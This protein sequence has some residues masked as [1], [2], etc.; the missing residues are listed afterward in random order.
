[1]VPCPN[2]LGGG[3]RPHRLGPLV[4]RHSPL[5][6]PRA[7]LVR[8][9]RVLWAPRCNHQSSL[10][11]RHSSCL[12]FIGLDL[13][14]VSSKSSSRSAPSSGLSSQPSSGLRPRRPGSLAFWHSPLCTLRASLVRAVRLH[15]NYRLGH[16]ASGPSTSPSGA[17]IVL[18]QASPSPS[19][20]PSLS[21]VP[22]LC[23]SS[24]GPATLPSWSPNL[25]AQSSSSV[26]FERAYF[27]ECGFEECAFIRTL[28]STF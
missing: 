16:L 26:A 12:V 5:R 8:G 21:S 18:A 27:E 22:S 19:S 6:R 23:H 25:L 10:R 15:Q 13:F 2:H 3:S 7:S 4:L 9:V 28:V 14:V 1:M 20:K 11:H 17:P 24:I